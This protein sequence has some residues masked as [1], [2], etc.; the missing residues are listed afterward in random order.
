GWITEHEDLQVQTLP[1]TGISHAASQDHGTA[2]LGVIAMQDNDIGGTGITPRVKPCVISRW[3]PDG[4]FN[5][6]DAIMAACT[7]LQY[8]DVLLL[9]AQCYDASTQTMLWPVE[10]QEACF[11]AIRLATALGIIVIE[12]AGNGCEG[13]AGNNL[14]RYTDPQGNN[15]LNLNH[16]DSGAI[17]VA[18]AGSTV[19]HRRIIYSN[20]GSRIDCY[21]WGEHVHTAGNYPNTSG[22]VIN[23]Y[24]KAFNG[25]SSA[26]A[27]IAGAA[28][29]VQSIAAANGLQRFGP[30]QMRSLL[31]HE[32]YG[33]P[34]ENG[35]ATDRIGSM[36]DL[37][38]IIPLIR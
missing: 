15:V 28:L 2:T 31:S 24:T 27:I 34:S 26:A 22:A 25:T 7:Y 6:A 13:K 1:L 32:P 38:K 8:G 23:L 30:K 5:T 3:R 12:A 33:T 29:S 11:Q 21:A 36:P 17:M 20:Y 19:P 18:A 16:R 4:S 37:R 10:I 35:H 14:D 9:E